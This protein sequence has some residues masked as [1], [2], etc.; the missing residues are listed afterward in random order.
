MVEI[1]K[2]N[3]AKLSHQT[4]LQIRADCIPQVDALIMAGWHWELPEIVNDH[5]GE[6]EPWQWYWRAPP[7]RKGSKG[8][9]YLS[10]QQAYNALINSV[11][12]K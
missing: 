2:E 9:R 5:Q 7:K 3:I 6:T 11:L 1:T 8:R 4:M 10:T 12:I